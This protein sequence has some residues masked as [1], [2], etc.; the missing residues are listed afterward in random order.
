MEIISV[1]LY[2]LPNDVYCEIFRHFL[3][4]HGIRALIRLSILSNIFRKLINDIT[5]TIEVL[6]KSIIKI[7]KDDQLKMFKGLK[8]LDLS[9]NFV[10]TNK[11]LEGL[12]LNE[13]DLTKNEVIT[14]DAI[15]PYI[16]LI[17]ITTIQLQEMQLKQWICIYFIF[18]II[19]I[20]QTTI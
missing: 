6:D 14:N 18:G 10:I 15:C 3:K 20:L 5:Q 8:I 7:I 16:L 17:S 11:G 13:L 19:K 9:S 4:M 1:D 12:L 2:W